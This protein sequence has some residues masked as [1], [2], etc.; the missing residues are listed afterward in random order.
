MNN[1][2][3]NL[4]WIEK[5]R[6]ESLDEVVSQNN[7]IETL[8]KFIEIG[9]LPHL[10][11]Y[12]GP[13]SGKT[14][15]ILAI[16]KRVYGSNI[17]FMVLELNASDTRGIEDVR[18]QIKNFAGTRNFFNSGTKLVILDEADNMTKEAQ[19][20]LRRVIETYTH[21]VRFCLICNYVSKIIPALQSRCTRF[22]FPPLKDSEIINRVKDIIT[23]ENVQI[24]QNGLHAVLS[25]SLGDMRKV[26]NIIQSTSLTHNPIKEK[27]VYL[28][29]GKPSPSDIASILDSLMNDTILNTINFITKIQTK[30][31]LDLL[32][33]VIELYTV[34][35]KISLNNEKLNYFLKEI[36]ELEQRLEGST[37]AEIQLGSLVS[38]F[39]QIRTN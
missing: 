10:L 17:G 7:I 4:P 16:A 15:T 32:D 3:Q 8:E 5:Y 37:N 19:S 34:V 14:S 22:R 31:G 36:S 11:F 24:T 13:G 38:I 33:I 26:L 9:Q 23:K 25:L 39:H 12:G 1:R 2:D 27:H 35:M 18:T 29:T 28:T 30:K 6:P 21:N 20:A